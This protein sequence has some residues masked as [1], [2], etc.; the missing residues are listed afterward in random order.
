ME[1]ALEALTTNTVG[2]ISVH[3]LA[4]LIE[5]PVER[6]RPLV[7]HGYLKVVKASPIFEWSIVARPGQRATEWLRNMFQPLELRPFVPLKEAGKL[8]GVTECE[9]LKYCKTGKIPVQS[10][11]V[12]GNLITFGALKS[13]A[14]ARHRY[15]KPKRLDRAGLLRYYLSEIE[16]VRWKEPP[17][18]SQRLEREIGRIATFKE[19]WRTICSVELIVA[20]RDA[21]TATECLRRQ[22]EISE[23]LRKS[24]QQILDLFKRTTGLEATWGNESPEEK[25]RAEGPMPL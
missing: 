13:L 22:K 9:V 18:Y 10:D 15:H 24:E 14:R 19:P 25:S 2:P 20:F 11:P 4:E 21:R 6:L 23:E 17:P 16:G 5:A 7:E 8:W 1:P 3:D 12:F